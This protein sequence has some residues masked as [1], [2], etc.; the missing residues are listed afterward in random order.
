[1]NLLERDM[2]IS[3]IRKKVRFTCI[4]QKHNLNDLRTQ[5]GLELG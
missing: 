2:V 1:M 3:L 5:H 4:K